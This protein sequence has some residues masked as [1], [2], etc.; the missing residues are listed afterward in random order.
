MTRTP[1]P[2]RS[3]KREFRFHH[4]RPLLEAIFVDRP[5]DLDV[6]Q[7]VADLHVVARRRD[8]IEFVALLHAE[9]RELRQPRFRHAE[10][11]AESN[12]TPNAV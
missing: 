8:Q 2:P 7:G 5:Q 3:R 12:A 6:H 9:R 4:G 1:S 10:T 11:Q